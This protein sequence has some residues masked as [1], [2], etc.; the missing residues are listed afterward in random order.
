L[1]FRWDGT[2]RY[3][4]MGLILAASFALLAGGCSSTKLGYGFASA[5]WPTEGG[6]FSRSSAAGYE[7]HPPF[8]LRWQAGAGVAPAGALAVLD[9]VVIGCFLRR[10]VAAYALDTGQALWERNL[11]TEPSSG[12]SASDGLL[13]FS[14]D[15][16]EGRIQCLNLSNG[17]T[18]WWADTGETTGA[19][20]AAGP[21]LYVC[22]RNGKLSRLGTRDGDIHWTKRVAPL[23]GASPLV[24][25]DVSI[26]TTLGDSV[27]AFAT[28]DGS[29]RWQSYVGAAQFGSAALWKDRCYVSTNDGYAVCLDLASGEEIWREPLGGRCM[30]SPSVRGDKVYCTDLSGRISCFDAASGEKHWEVTEDAPIRATP[31]V[32]GFYCFTAGMGG[33]VSCYDRESGDI[34]WSEA[35]EDAFETPPVV[36]E[37]FLVLVSSTGTIYCYKEDI[38]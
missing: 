21:Y 14:T 17:K 35:V 29:V 30:S 9:D 32:S 18:V 16:P 20:T 4:Y 38:R 11:R 36:A 10:T 23:A 8:Y 28:G 1:T 25:D 3:I 31:T 12:P 37:M 6:D 15:I 19:P 27:V 2:T 26:V 33:R 24:G 7:A 34:L 13:Y 5:S 22:A